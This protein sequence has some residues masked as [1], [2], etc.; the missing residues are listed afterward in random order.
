M[1]HDILERHWISIDVQC[2]N[3]RAVPILPQLIFEE[4]G[5]IRRSSKTLA[6]LRSCVGQLTIGGNRRSRE[7]EQLG[8]NLDGKHPFWGEGALVSFLR[9]GSR[10]AA[11]GSGAGCGHY[12]VAAMDS[13]FRAGSKNERNSRVRVKGSIARRSSLVLRCHEEVALRPHCDRYGY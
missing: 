11:L 3:V 12:S 13:G 2:S 5:E 7:T 10:Y 8:A 4:L 9:R 6:R 1:S